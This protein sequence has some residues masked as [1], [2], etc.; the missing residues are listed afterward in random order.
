MLCVF[1]CHIRWTAELCLLCEIHPKSFALR[2][3]QRLHRAEL[4]RGVSYRCHYVS[5]QLTAGVSQGSPI[6]PHKVVTPT[7]AHLNKRR[8]TVTKPT[9]LL[10]STFVQMAFAFNGREKINVF[11]DNAL[12]PQIFIFS[13]KKFLH[14]AQQEGVRE[15]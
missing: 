14:Q 5:N 6:Y 2:S 12:T 11:V 9:A 13:L 3:D 8:I 7:W 10:Q 15:H 4:P 1:I